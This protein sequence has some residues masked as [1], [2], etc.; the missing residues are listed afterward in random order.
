MPTTIAITGDQHS[1]S[2]IA[3]CPPVINL[4]DGGTYHASRGQRWLWECWLDYWDTVRGIAAGAPIIGVFNGDLGE[5]DTKRRSYQ[6]I[7]PNKAVIL[8]LVRQ[9]IAPALAVCDRVYFIRG[10]QAHV[11]KSAWLEEEIA[12]DT[13]ITVRDHQ[14]ASWYHLRAKLER[15]R[16]DIAHHASM[17]GLPWSEKHAALRMVERVLWRYAIDM[18][19]ESPGV[20]VR[21]HNHKYAD[22]GNNY[23]TVGYCLPCWSLSTEY[24]YRT[25]R[26]NDIADIGGII[27]TVYGDKW[28]PVV[29]RYQPKEAR[30]IWAMTM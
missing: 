1:N 4:D 10:T 18:H 11:G 30:R 16:F 8:E 23:P 17:G 26:E 14:A 7:S 5:L 12:Q 6:L 20:V 25:G 9:T 24:G 19:A 27:I 15:V 21:S 28:E 3:L 22:S 2:K 13:T 29:K